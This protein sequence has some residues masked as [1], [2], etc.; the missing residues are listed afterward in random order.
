LVEPDVGG[1]PFWH[2]D[3]DTYVDRRDA[4]GDQHSDTHANQD[5]HRDVHAD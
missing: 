3:A 4:D 2:R 1:W 5:G